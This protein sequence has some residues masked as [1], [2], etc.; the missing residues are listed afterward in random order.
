MPLGDFDR[1]V[2]VGPMGQSGQPGHP[3]YDD[4]NTLWNEG[5]YIPFPF[6]R[7][8]I[9]DRAVATLFLGPEQSTGR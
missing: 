1:T 7:E 4:M 6:S 3:H 2:V 5:G 8:L 9:E